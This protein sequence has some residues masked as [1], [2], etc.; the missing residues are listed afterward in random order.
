MKKLFMLMLIGLTIGAAAQAQT[1]T[2]AKPTTTA[3]QKVHNT[4]SRHKR[5]KG[6]KI[7]SKAGDNKTS[8]EVNTKTGAVKTK[9]N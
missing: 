3:V 6:Y 4:V 7:K 1:E 9:D 8:T 2:K 5:Y